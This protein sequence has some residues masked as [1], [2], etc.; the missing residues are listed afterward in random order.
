MLLNN[1][2]CFIN[3][4]IKKHPQ[5]ADG[6]LAEWQPS[7]ETQ[8]LIDTE[9]LK[10][11]NNDI[12]ASKPNY[13]VDDEKVEHRNIRIPY[14]ANKDPSFGDRI[15]LGDIYERWNLIGTSGWNWQDKQSMWVGFDFDSIANHTKGL[16][17]DALKAMVSRVRELPYVTARKSKSGKGIHLIV[18]L[19]PHPTTRTHAE[20]KQLAKHVL[21]QMSSDSGLNLRAS[22]DVY[23]G[24]LWHWQKGLNENGL[25]L[26]K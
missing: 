3:G 17:E 26:I 7:H 1:I 19:N 11:R 13:W 12:H 24:I 15:I 9:G 4:Q 25:Q 22:V 8:I 20:H 6:P 16:A 23:G 14:N 18:P 21:G 10:P 5:L 2:K